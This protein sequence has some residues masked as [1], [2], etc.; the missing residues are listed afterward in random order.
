MYYSLPKFCLLVKTPANLYLTII[1]NYILHHGIV[2]PP[3]NYDDWG[4][5]DSSEDD[6]VSDKLSSSDGDVDEED[7]E[8]KKDSELHVEA[9]N[10]PFAVSL[11]TRLKGARVRQPGALSV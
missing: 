9:H 5:I 11:G 3:P 6:L 10:L 2:S 4:V 7:E 8:E 1:Y